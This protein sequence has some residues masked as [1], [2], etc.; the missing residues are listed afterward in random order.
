MGWTMFLFRTSVSLYSVANSFILGLFVAPQFVGYFA[1]AEKMIKALL[2][3]FTPVTQT[4]YPRVSHLVQHDRNR[5]ARL[6]RFGAVILSAEGVALGT[7]TFIFAPLA[8]RLVLGAAFLPAVPVLRVLSFLLPLIGLNTAVGPQWMLPLGMDRI[9]VRIILV[10]GLI[11]IGLASVLARPYAGLGMAMAVVS[12][13]L[14][15]GVQVNL[16][17]HR[18]HLHPLAYTGRISNKIQGS[19]TLT[20][21]T[22]LSAPACGSADKLL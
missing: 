7:I 6:A 20:E 2:Q 5:A 15:I 16:V 22:E 21:A 17:L 12:A 19:W 10:A 13:E 9:F 3:L 8:V 14:F 4:L 11:N 1:G 18:R